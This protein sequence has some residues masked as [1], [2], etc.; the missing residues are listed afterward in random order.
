MDLQ[1]ILT[2]HG[3]P[4]LARPS[5]NFQ[6]QLQG[7]GLPYWP[8]RQATTAVTPTGILKIEGCL[9]ASLCKEPGWGWGPEKTRAVRSEILRRINK[10][11]CSS[12]GL[13]SQL[14]DGGFKVQDQPAQQHAI[15]L[16]KER[17][18]AL[19]LERDYRAGEVLETGIYSP[20]RT[21]TVRCQYAV[22]HSP[23]PA[24]CWGLGYKNRFRRQHTINTGTIIFLI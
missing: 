7:Q 21:L 6:G 3:W 15:C 11:L 16:K 8:T 10:A 22:L 9:F 18:S 2:C 1:V 23:Q 19:H 24:F 17:W 4:R 14:M 20:P 12:V 5:V 13:Q